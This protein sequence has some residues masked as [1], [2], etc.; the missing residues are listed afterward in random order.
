MRLSAITDGVLGEAIQEQENDEF[1]THD[2]IFWISRNRP[3]PYVQDLYLALQDDGDPFVSLHTAVGRRLA[4]LTDLVRQQHRKR[5]SANVRGEITECEVWRHAGA[6]P[7]REG[8]GFPPRLAPLREML[9]GVAR[10]GGI[11]HYG[12]VAD[13]L[14]IRAERLDHCAELSEALDEISTFEHENGRPLLSVV[15]VR[16]PDEENSMRP[17]GGFFKMARRNGVQKPDEDDD[18]FFSAELR[19]CHE[20]WGRHRE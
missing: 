11:T 10:R 9:I 16:K 8:E 1:D 15:V 14:G 19:R 12:P 6:A 18:A 5:R 17:G 4:A 7:A 13:L 3:R 2:V 20:Y